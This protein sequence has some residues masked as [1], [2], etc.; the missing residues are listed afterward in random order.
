[1]FRLSP[2]SQSDS[3]A[4]LNPMCL[5][6]MYWTV[7]RIFH[8]SIQI[9][10]NWSSEG[11]LYVDVSS[12]ILEV[13]RTFMASVP[14]PGFIIVTSVTIQGCCSARFYYF[15]SCLYTFFISV[16]SGRKYLCTF[17]FIL[18]DVNYDPVVSQV[19]G[20]HWSIVSPDTRNM[21]CRS[22]LTSHIQ[23]HYWSSVCKMDIA[24]MCGFADAILTDVCCYC[25]SV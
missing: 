14:N 2:R 13:T 19:L 11:L 7:N 9:N 20:A 10:C 8:I 25:L 21:F 22:H 24:F 6:S 23:L 17:I 3:S 1:M 12:E 4:L 15:T 5:L 16:F 18:E